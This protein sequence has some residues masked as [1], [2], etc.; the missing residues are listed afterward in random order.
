LYPKCSNTVNKSSGE[1]FE[2]SNAY[3]ERNEFIENL[4][5]FFHKMM[6]A[7]FDFLIDEAKFIPSVITS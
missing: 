5:N 6:Q 1:A 3:L 4:S 7:L 2:S